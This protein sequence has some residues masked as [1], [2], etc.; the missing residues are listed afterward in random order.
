MTAEN[1]QSVTLQSIS[2]FEEQ[3]S[4][5]VSNVNNWL[6]SPRDNDSSSLL[7]IDS[8]LIVSGGQNSNTQN[9]KRTALNDT[10]V[11]TA[12][13]VETPIKPTFKK[14][15]SPNLIIEVDEEDHVSPKEE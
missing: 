5:N 10:L 15:P 6:S 2:P 4:G 12:S 9:Q 8:S 7:R 14:S 13:I 1:D 3:K 11:Q